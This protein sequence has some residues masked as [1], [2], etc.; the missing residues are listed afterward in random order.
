M[1]D[2]FKDLFS[3]HAADYRAFRMV[4]QYGSPDH[5]PVAADV[6]NYLTWCKQ[7]EP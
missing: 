7:V 1:S 5:P 4:T 6:L 3:G 2:A